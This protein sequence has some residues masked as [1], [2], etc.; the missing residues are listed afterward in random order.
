MLVQLVAHGL[1][2]VPPIYIY[3]GVQFWHLF[4]DVHDQMERS[5]VRHDH[6]ERRC[7]R[8]LLV[9]GSRWAWL[10]RRTGQLVN[11]ATGSHCRRNDRLVGGEERIELVAR[12]AVRVSSLRL[13]D[14]VD[15]VDVAGFSGLASALRR[16]SM[17]PA[18]PAS[19]RRRSRGEHDVR[20][21]AAWSLQAQ[22]QRPIPALAWLIAAS[23]SSHWRSAVCQ[24][25]RR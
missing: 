17:A 5:R 14:Q 1:L 18:F 21:V 24:R 6:V 15:D 22:S 23:M 2:D 10:V 16:L 11:P 13:Q 8:I 25:R 3:M 19:A 4:R 9:A 7:R 20:F 12:Q